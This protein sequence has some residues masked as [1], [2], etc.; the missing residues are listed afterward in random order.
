MP[1]ATAQAPNTYRKACA[2]R[3][4]AMLMQTPL[5]RQAD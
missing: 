3:M 1:E 2:A 5:M 4:Q